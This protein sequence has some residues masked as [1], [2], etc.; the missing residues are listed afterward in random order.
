M[1][2]AVG[3]A[4]PSAA[5]MVLLFSVTAT[6]SG[7]TITLEP[8]WTRQFGTIGPAVDI[9]QA[10]D[11]DGNTYV[12]GSTSGVLPGQSSA[13][14]TDA[15]VRKYNSSGDE[16]WTRQ[17][18]TIGADQAFA[19]SV[20][21]SGVYVAGAAGRPLPG[22]TSTGGTDAF[23]RKYDHDGQQMWTRQF[24]S[25]ASDQALGISVGPSG[26]YV[27]GRTDGALPGQASAGG[28]DAFVRSYDSSGILIWTHQFGTDGFDQAFGVVVDGAGYAY[29]AGQTDGS[30][31]GQANQGGFDAFVRQFDASGTAVWTRQF[32]TP[33]LDQA[34]GISV[35][36]GGVYAAGATGGALAQPNVGL[37]DAF[38]RKYDLSG[39]Q[40]WTRQFGT[41]LNDQAFG[42]SLDAS[43][44][45]VVGATSGPLVLPHIGLQDAYVHKLDP[46][47]G[48]S[49]WL[50]QFGTSGTD[51]ALGVSVNA[52]NVRVV[53]STTG[54][55][56][57]QTSAGATDAFVR[58][59][60]SAGV[61]AW[62]RQF[63]GVGPA[64]DIVQAQAPDADGNVYVVGSVGGPLPGQTSAGSTDAFVRKYDPA[65]NEIW[66]R[67]FGSSASDVALGVAVD[68]AAVYVT[69]HTDGALPFQTSI[70][71]RD[72]FVRKYDFS[73][74]E[75]WTRQFGTPSLDQA[76]GISIN[77]TG[78]YVAGSTG[79]A[80][81]GHTSAGALDCYVRAFDAD[82]NMIWTRQFGTSVFD[83]I[84]A[85][86]ADDNG[87]YVAGRTAGTLP[88]QQTAGTQDAFLRRY[89]LSGDEAWTH[90]FGTAANDQA[91]AIAAAAAGVYVAGSTSGALPGQVNVGVQDAFVRKYDAG[92]AEIWTRQFGTLAT[93]QI[94]GISVRASSVYLAGVTGFALP[95]QTSA[96]GTDAFASR[97]TE[98]GDEIW[99][100]QFGTV[101]FDQA[102]SVASA[103]WGVYIG[104]S[105]GIDVDAFVL[106]LREVHDVAI[107]IKPG[108]SPN[109][110]NLGSHGT[111]PVAILSMPGFDATTVNPTTV[112]LAGASVKV[113]GKGTPIASFTDVDADGLL[114]LMLHVET[115]ALQ[116]SDTDTEAVLL[117][118]TFEGMHIRGVDTIRVVP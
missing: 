116:L 74:A 4:R 46:L 7:Q 10:A 28:T 27:A 111:V 35:D 104:G 55:L 115:E 11:A 92:G 47:N 75:T 57:G 14:G 99:T 34:L 77:S 109:T 37:Q 22:Q 44:A 15:F 106:K 39:N 40:V 58:S 26:V 56:P 64:S 2:I 114:D 84:D 97:Y 71:G 45:Y 94:F 59:Y 68:A 21:A 105:A 65:G 54:T 91:F 110:V 101:A 29:V 53:G 118:Q 24:G 49:M 61:E 73:G 31:P 3:A 78:V 30:L 72:T 42:I 67:Q 48:S 80:F 69:G 96:G 95:G 63:G 6:A 12:A 33:A 81:P 117:G 20:D 9:A 43:G 82:G 88:D 79:G 38:V 36:A 86:S 5:L 113:K 66:T 112:T 102:L 8:E 41:S 93:D 51:V 103:P 25:S 70:G 83:Q 62:T 17:F 50:R 107:D 89:Y 87:V 16:V 100:Y 1:R 19:I 32:G 76:F 52:G 90:Q 98:D 108:V 13:G 60:D 18:G 85:I 23:V